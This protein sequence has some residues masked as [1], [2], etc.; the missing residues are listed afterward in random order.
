MAT[1]T[2]QITLQS[3]LLSDELSVVAETTLM[4]GGTTADGLDQ[5]DYG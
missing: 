1:T 5:L 4:K 2:A 3:D